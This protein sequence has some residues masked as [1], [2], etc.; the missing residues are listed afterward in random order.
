MKITRSFFSLI[1]IVLLSFNLAAQKSPDASVVTNVDAKQFIDLLSK[2]DGVLIDLRTPAE[3]EK[4]FIKG[5]KMIDFTDKNY[6][7][8]FAKLDKN[9]TTYIYCAGGGRSGSAAEYMQEHGFKKVV[10]LQKGFNDWKKQGL[11]VEMK[12]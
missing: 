11:S 10:N 1:C 7:Q 9:K 8:E 5:S 4:G 6:E 12:K 2:N 3:I